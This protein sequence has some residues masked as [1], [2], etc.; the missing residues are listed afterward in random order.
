MQK[1]G[2]GYIHHSIRDPHHTAVSRSIRHVRRQDWCQY[3]EL[4]V[5][6]TAWPDF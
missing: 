4:C 6:V 3:Y 1:G 2:K 5:C